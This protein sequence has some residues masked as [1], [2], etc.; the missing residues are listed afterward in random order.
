MQWDQGSSSWAD[1]QAAAAGTTITKSGVQTGKTYKFK[2]RIKNRKGWS[3]YSPVVSY[4]TGTIA[5]PPKEFWFT[6]SK[7]GKLKANWKPPTSGSGGLT[8]YKLGF[9]GK[10]ETTGKNKWFD[11]VESMDISAGDCVDWEK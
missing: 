3:E 5:D 1:V 2:Y 4:F 9:R 8:G 6:T 7:D 11:L 10:D